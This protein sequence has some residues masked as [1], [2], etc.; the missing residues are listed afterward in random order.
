[1]TI[2]SGDRFIATRTADGQAVPFKIVPATASGDRAMEIVAADGKRVL[3]KLTPVTAINDIGFPV[4]TADGNI[5][6]VKSESPCCQQVVAFYDWQT[7]TWSGPRHTYYCPRTPTSDQYTVC[8]LTG[9]TECTGAHSGDPTW[10]IIN[11]VCC[12]Y[13]TTGAAFGDGRVM[14]SYQYFP[15]GNVE[16]V[17]I[18]SGWFCGENVADCPLPYSGGTPPDADCYWYLTGTP[19][20]H[21]NI[22]N[23][24]QWAIDYA[25]GAVCAPANQC[26]PGARSISTWTLLDCM[27]VGGVVWT[28]NWVAAAAGIS[29]IL[30]KANWLGY[31]A[32]PQTYT[33]ADCISYSLPSLPN[34]AL[35]FGF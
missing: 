25:Y 34:P 31:K 30:T 21:Y 15:N 24:P 18:Y 5:V 7:G 29:G 11:G 19:R 13:C 20:L 16:P 3:A 35:C 10:S 12:K 26:W 27:K 6:L 28:A 23:T 2:A 8:T 33:C 14:L 1:M 17:T 22:H 9:Q 4:V 32:T